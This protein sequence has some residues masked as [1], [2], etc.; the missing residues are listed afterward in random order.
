MGTL[1]D[2]PAELQL[3]VCHYLKEA[4][5][6][7]LLALALTCKDT[8]A[9][10]LEA[11]NAEQRIDLGNGEGRKVHQLLQHLLLLAKNQHYKM[12][13]VAITSTGDAETD[14]II[15]Y[16]SKFK[17]LSVTFPDVYGTPFPITDRA[18]LR[19]YLNLSD[20][21]ESAGQYGSRSWRDK[22]KSGNMKDL[23][24]LLLRVTQHIT[25]LKM[26]GT[27]AWTRQTELQ[28]TCPVV[29]F[30]KLDRV[31]DTMLPR[32]SMFF[33]ELPSLRTLVFANMTVTC[34]SLHWFGAP[35]SVTDLHFINCQVSVQTM[36]KA[37]KVCHHL[38]RFEYRAITSRRDDTSLELY[39]RNSN[40]GPFSIRIKTPRYTFT[41]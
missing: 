31:Q 21:L 35:L 33:F 26:E 1:R 4:D 3:E 7:S 8:K 6:A 12:P 27:F 14:D 5:H 32:G 9:C 15:R 40:G 13:N 23:T 28:G 41:S 25:E 19:D 38:Q 29:H 11:Y 34:K 39:L 22:F 37:V 36:G 20:H 18:L 17:S 16:A 24:R 30:L 10:A 2:L